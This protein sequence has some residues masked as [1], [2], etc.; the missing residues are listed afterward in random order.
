MSSSWLV[1]SVVSGWLALSLLLAM[2]TELLAQESPALE[3]INCGH[4]GTGSNSDENSYPENTMSS[5]LQ[6]EAEGA[7]MVELDVVHSADGVLVVIHDDTVD[8]T[9]DGTGCVGDLTMA[10]LELLDAGYGT[11]LEGTGE[12]L[13]TL[14]EVLDVVAVDI[15]IEIKIDDTASCPDSDKPALAADVIAAIRADS[16][17]RRIVVSSFDAE[18]L[19]EIRQEAADIHLG[20]LTMDPGD[21][22]EA[23]ELGFD[24]LNLLSL[25]AREESIAEVHSLG[26]DLAVWTENDPWRMEDHLL[27]G[28]DM[29]ITDEPDLFQSVRA[30]YCETWAADQASSGGCAASEGGESGTAVMLALFYLLVCRRRVAKP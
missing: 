10:E 9:T 19:S 24:G 22:A 14:A 25:T 11:S 29:V 7:E 2:S 6:A 1:R 5:F 15:N 18:V 30:E 28:V 20:L 3:V 23:V 12:L 13:P 8:R 26:L 21:A 16:K 17:A 4:R 27:F